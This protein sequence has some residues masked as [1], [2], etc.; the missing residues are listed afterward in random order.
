MLDQQY[1]RNCIK[2]QLCNISDMTEQSK[3]VQS[4]LLD[5]IEKHNFKH[6][7][8]FVPLKKT[9]INEIDLTACIQQLLNKGIHCYK[10]QIT[11]NEMNFVP[12]TLVDEKLDVLDKSYLSL[13]IFEK[14]DLV[15]C[16]GLVFNEKGHR[17]GRGKGYYDKTLSFCKTVNKHFLTIGVG[18]DIQNLKHIEWKQN[19]TD[20]NI[21]FVMFPTSK[22]IKCNNE[23]N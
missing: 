18:F 2:K 15:I 9:N 17:I 4:M 12:I 8:C 6:I 5:F 3:V 13:E 11:N 16:P 1:L 20:I 22:L 7:A 23:I 19:S 21:D 14:I 10:P